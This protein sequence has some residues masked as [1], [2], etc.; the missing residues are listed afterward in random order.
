MPEQHKI[1]LDLSVA[2]DSATHSDN[3]FTS[4]EWLLSFTIHHTVKMY[5]E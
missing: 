4:A 5:G 3:N 1:V 2:E